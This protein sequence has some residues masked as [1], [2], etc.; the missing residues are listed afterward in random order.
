MSTTLLDHRAELAA[1][2]DATGRAFGLDRAFVEKDFW[3]TEVLR[4]VAPG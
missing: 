4:A 1:L 2:V 3:V